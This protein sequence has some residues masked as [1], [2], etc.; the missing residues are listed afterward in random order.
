MCGSCGQKYNG[1]NQNRAHRQLVRYRNL[2]GGKREV[3]QETP[4]EVKPPEP[5]KPVS[6]EEKKDHQ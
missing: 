6:T 1:L 3:V 5:E 2:R 4:S